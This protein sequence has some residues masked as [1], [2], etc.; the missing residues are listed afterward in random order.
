[1][2]DGEIT[3]IFEYHYTDTIPYIW[4]GGIIPYPWFRYMKEVIKDE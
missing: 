2:T 1:M 3:E 4:K